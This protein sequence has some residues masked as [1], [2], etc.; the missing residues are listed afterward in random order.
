M[1]EHDKIYILS[2]DG[3]WYYYS[4]TAEDWLV[5]GTYGGAVTDTTLSISGRPADAKAVGDAVD[6]LDDRV[7]ALES[8]SGGGLT[9]DIK[10]ALLACFANVAWANENGQTYYNALDAALNP[11][12]NLSSIT[13]VYTQSGTVYDT[14]S[15]DDLKTDLVVTAHW[16]DNTTS[17]ITTYTLSGTLTVGTST[18]TVSYGGKTTTFTV[19]VTEYVEPPL[20]SWDFTNSNLTDSVEGLVAVTNATQNSDGIKFESADKYLVLN[21]E[22]GMSLKSKRVEIDIAS[23]SNGGSYHSRLFSVTSNSGYKTNA[24]ADNFMWKSSNDGWYVYSGSW[25]TLSLAKA[26]YPGSYFSGK[27]LVLTFDSS[28]YPTVSVDGTDLLTYDKAMART[29]YL[30]IGG[31]YSDQLYRLAPTISAVRIYEGV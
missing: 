20:Y 9:A 21:T 22:G 31:S 4:A 1:T 17:T 30:V 7:T 18:I 19:A 25:S 14:A 28:G 29:G 26:D 5:G 11:P 15:L 27:T 16:S 3:K 2:S 12:A 23:M 13:C 8:G 10:S 6:A 24:D